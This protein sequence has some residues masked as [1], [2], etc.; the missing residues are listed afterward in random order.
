MSA[1]DDVKESVRQFLL[2]NPLQG[3]SAANVPDDLRLRTSG[4][5]D[6]LATVRLVGFVERRFGIE[7]EPHEAGVEHF[8]SIA[9]LAAL[10]ERK[11]ARTKNGT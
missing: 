7:I 9:D 10:I 4:L 11:R 3:E 8:D 1:N 5:L 2:A 6:S